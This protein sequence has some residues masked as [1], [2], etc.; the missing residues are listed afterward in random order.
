M[1]KQTKLAPKLTIKQKKFVANKVKGMKNAQAYKEAGYSSSSRAVAE[2]NSSRL[3]KQDNIQKAI[4]KA[5]EFHEATPEFAVGR[6]KAIAEQNK[7]L[8]ASRLASKDLLEL[9]GWK[10]GDRPTISVTADNIGFF[11]NVR[12]IDNPPTPST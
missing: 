3:L 8:G 6:L 11:G 10:R 2:V 1:T 12:S 5:L 4:D 9:H 7:E